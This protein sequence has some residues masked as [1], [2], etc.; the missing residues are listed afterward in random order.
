MPQFGPIKRREL[1]A[2]LR[3]LGF[4]GPYAGGKHEFMQRGD[5][6]L[7]IPNPHGSEIGPKLLGRV[8]RQVGIERRQWEEL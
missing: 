5:V 8:L 4:S 1:I 6:S 2:C 7:S 3:R